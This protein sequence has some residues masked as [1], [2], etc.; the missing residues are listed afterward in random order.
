M[1]RT[2]AQ[3]RFTA[4]ESEPLPRRLSMTDPVPRA[5]AGTAVSASPLDALPRDLANRADVQALLRRF[6]SRV[7][8][9]GVLA[10]PFAEIRSRGLESHLPV[11]CDFWETVLF[12]AGLYRRNTFQAH[13]HVH[14]WTPLSTKHFLRWLTLWNTTIDEMYRGPITEHAKVQAARIASSMHH[15]LTGRH[16]T[17]L[18]PAAAVAGA[19]VTPSR[20]PTA[21]TEPPKQN[22]TERQTMN[23]ENVHL[24]RI[25]DQPTPADGTRVLVDRI[26]PRGITKVRA[27]LD[28]WCKQIAP[29][30]ELRKWYH[31]DPARFEEFTRRYREELTETQR[32]AALKDLRNL[33]KRETLTLL[34]AT[35]DVNRSEAAVL[36][37]LLRGRSSTDKTARA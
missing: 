31:H 6:Y 19:A 9:D 13:L 15:R 28:R 11:M 25:Y 32:A 1:I 26:W 37:D 24:R 16:A 36:A 5:G 21:H 18:N 22:H 34:T 27:H 35:T 20:S 8:A 10:E 4:T 30:T 29:S 12:R 23:R 7:L 17:E 33:A 2:P 14:G 3:Q